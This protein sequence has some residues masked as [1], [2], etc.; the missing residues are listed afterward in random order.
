MKLAAMQFLLGNM[1]LGLVEG[2]YY[3]TPAGFLWMVFFIMPLELARMQEGGAARIVAENPA[4]FFLA[5]TLGFFVNFLSYGVIQNTSSLTFKVLGQLK[6]VAVVVVSTALFGN[7]VSG[8]QAL[9][10]AVSIVGF[11]LYNRAK[12][13]PPASGGPP[14]GGVEKDEALLPEGGPPAEG[15]G[16]TT[17]LAGGRHSVVLRSI[18]SSGHVRSSSLDEVPDVGPGKL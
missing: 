6:N 1:K 15:A 17:P 13:G 18:S 12:S 3:F 16:G 7:V 2:I 8:L 14:G 5:A 11:G 4:A 10:Y 9:G